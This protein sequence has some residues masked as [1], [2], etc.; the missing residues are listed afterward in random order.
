MNQLDRNRGTR[1][2]FLR[3][4]RIGCIAAALALLAACSQSAGTTSPDPNGTPRQGGALTMLLP[5][6]A[7][8]LDP[9]TAS[10][11]NVA[12][13]SR[14]SAL[15]DVL[16]W[17]DPSTGTLRPQLAESLQPEGD[18]SVWILTLRSGIRFTDGA[19]LDA[20]AVKRAWEAHKLPQLRSLAAPTVATLGLTVLDKLRLSI[21]LP[22]PNANFD[23]MVA[24]T[25]NFIPSPKTLENAQTVDASR[26]APVGAGPFRLREWVP[27]DHMTF[28]RNPDYWQRDKGLPYLDSVTFKVNVDTPSGSRI[29]DEGGADLTVSTDA[30]LINDARQRGLSV[31]EI[32]LNG[33][34]MVAFNMRPEQD[35]KKPP[36]PFANPDLRRA[37]VLS[38]ST[39]EIDRRFYNSAGAPA[40]G[41]FD[42]S[43]PL[44]N[45]QLTSPE[46][47]EPQAAALFA[48]LTQ[49]GRKPVEITYVVPNS[50]KAT[51][52]AQYVKERIE[53]VSKRTVTVNVAAE[54][55]P[56][57]IKRTSLDG[58]FDVAT[59]Q[60]WADDAEP[61]IFQFLH[62]QGGNTNLTGYNNPEVDAALEEARLATDPGQRREAYTRVQVQLNKDLPF[63]V[64]QEAVAAYV[65]DPK[66]TG[67]QL[68]NDGVLLFDRIGI[69]K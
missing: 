41:I 63:L 55:I 18:A 40:K 54:D 64:Y 29:I 33:G 68:F 13:G 17:S 23:R 1:R 60:L 22:A 5:G 49:N 65:C 66:V 57:F 21:K 47:D 4:V 62:S 43:S 9:Y 24:R 37:V 6:D 53:T 25:L 31:G 28:E 16:L 8:G 2:R 42:S 58:N 34:L 51:A 15:Y 35:K 12:D 30:L 69:R 67:L 44:A 48:Q 11:S 61:T 10:A 38:L 14:L 27:N 39:A 52:I 56:N 26:R 36:R 32:P 3:N 50:P 46:N 7:R 20:E 45:T 59:F 19:D